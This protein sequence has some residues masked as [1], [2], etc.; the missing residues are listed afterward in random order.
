MNK[1]QPQRSPSLPSQGMLDNK[2]KSQGIALTDWRKHALQQF[3]PVTRA[4]NLK[5]VPGLAIREELAFHCS[6][7]PLPQKWG[8]FLQMAIF[9]QN[10]GRGEGDWLLVLCVQMPT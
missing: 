7:F 5:H 9:S 4:Q 1:A 10:V 3:L 8:H 2:G 6:S